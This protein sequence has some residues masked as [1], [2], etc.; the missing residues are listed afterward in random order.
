LNRVE[1]AQQTTPDESLLADR[2]AR[3]R[4]QLHDARLLQTSISRR[5][6]QLADQLE[7]LVSEQLVA[8]FRSFLQM[9]IKLLCTVKEIE[10]KLQ[11]GR[12]QRDALE[13]G[14]ITRPLSPA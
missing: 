12:E 7:Q 10:E 2:C 13:R 1:R 5:S 3:L 6:D 9:Q 4:D 8:S 14:G 11:L